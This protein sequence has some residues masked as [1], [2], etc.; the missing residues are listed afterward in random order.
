MQTILI[1]TD[2]ARQH[3]LWLHFYA[4]TYMI[5]FPWSAFLSFPAVASPIVLWLLILRSVVPQNRCPL[6]S[7]P[8]AFP[9]LSLAL[10]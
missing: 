7:A 3:R 8:M 1:L 5:P 4:F 6:P 2:T 10:L 9:V